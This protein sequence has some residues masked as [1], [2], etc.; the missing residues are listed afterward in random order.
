VDEK[1]QKKKWA[2]KSWQ[3]FF[4][5]SWHCGVIIL[6]LCS[7]A[8]W[9]KISFCQKKKCYHSAHMKNIGFLENLIVTYCIWVEI[10]LKGDF[11]EKNMQGQKCP[12][13]SCLMNFNLLHL[14][15]W[16]RHMQ[17]RWMSWDQIYPSVFFST[18]IFLICLLLIA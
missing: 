1:N 10:F 14:F 2:K 3:G 8:L 18:S 9:S 4:F 5:Q 7:W 12:Q 6:S 16:E 13:S 17:E 11:Y 15:Y